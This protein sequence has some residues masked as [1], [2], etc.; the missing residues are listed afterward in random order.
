M[1]LR[2]FAKYPRRLGFLG[3]VHS[4]ATAVS[5]LFTCAHVSATAS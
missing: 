1:P 3:I 5:T 2:L 4:T